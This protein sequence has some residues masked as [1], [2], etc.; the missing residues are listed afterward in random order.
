MNLIWLL[1]ILQQLL[2][3]NSFADEQKCKQ[4]ITFKRNYKHHTGLERILKI[5]HG[6][7]LQVDVIYR[8]FLPVEWL[9]SITTCLSTVYTLVLYLINKLFYFK[10]LLQQWQG[11]QERRWKDLEIHLFSQQVGTFINWF[12]YWSP[13]INWFTP[14]LF[15]PFSREQNVARL[16]EKLSWT[17]SRCSKPFKTK[18]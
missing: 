6:Q 5:I 7:V 11:Q 1:F 10:K 2:W 17:S 3:A 4:F 13:V 16:S 15:V 14:V 18:K 8:L 9:F 12:W